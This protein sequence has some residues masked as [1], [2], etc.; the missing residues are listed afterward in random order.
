MANLEDNMVEITIRDIFRILLRRWWIVL[1]F[2]I[3]CG[4]ASYI[5]TNYYITPM[6]SAN[7][8]LYV[9]KNTDQYGIETTDLYLGSNLILDYSEIAKSKLVAYEVIDELGLR[10]SAGALAGRISVNQRDMTR[11]IQISV[12]DSNPQRAMDIANTVAEVFKKKVV[13]IMQVENVQV[14][15]RAELPMFP[16]SP[17]KQVNYMAGVILGLALGV[18]LIFLIEF[19]D[20]TVKTPEDVQKYTGL[21]VI[22]TIPVFHRKGRRA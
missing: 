19:L 10:M 13:E 9:G 22:G 20:D 8:T 3:V 4:T 5:W 17:N 21:P 16:V 7:T 6:Y 2:I 1:I 14:I 11:V 15:D 18:G 12:T